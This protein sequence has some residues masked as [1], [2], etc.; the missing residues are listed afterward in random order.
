MI[1]PVISSL[2]AEQ[3]LSASCGSGTPDVEILRCAQDDN[4]LRM[5]GPGV[6]VK[7]HNRRWFA[8]SDWAEKNRPVKNILLEKERY[9]ANRTTRVP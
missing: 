7:T 9:D 5:T 4:A 6:M 1:R 8:V 3:A 2:L